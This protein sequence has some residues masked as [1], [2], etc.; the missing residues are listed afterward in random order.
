MKK[1]IFLTNDDGIYASGLI[2][3]EN[4]LSKSNGIFFTSAPL[5]EKSG[6]GHSITLHSPLRI[7][8]FNENKYAVDGTPTDS[9]FLGLN[10]L[11]S[12]KPDLIVSGINRGANLANDLTYSGTF[13]AALEGFYHNI[14][15][16]AVSLFITDFSVFND[17]FFTSCAKIFFEKVLPFIEESVGEEFYLKPHLINVN[18]PQSAIQEDIDSIII[19]WTKL[20]KRLYGGA[21]V[22]RVDPRGRD[23]YWI[24]GDQS[25]FVDFPGSDCNSVLAGKISVTPIKISLTDDEKLIYLKSVAR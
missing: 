21:V 6:V 15:S 19:E 11:S 25:G 1:R 20:G 17:S 22:K 24:G 3:L 12:V 2:A 16:I 10:H 13:S 5:H 23:Y 18:I 8:E 9:V 7:H 4:Y 14:S